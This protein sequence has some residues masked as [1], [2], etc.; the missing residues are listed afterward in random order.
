LGE[1]VNA[2]FINT[3][4]TIEVLKHTPRLYGALLVFRLLMGYGFEADME[5]LTKAL[6]KKKDGTA[7]DLGIYSDPA[8]KC[9]CQLLKLVEAHKE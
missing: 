3:D 1:L 8:H 6:P 7:V 5:Q 2:F 4:D 9:A